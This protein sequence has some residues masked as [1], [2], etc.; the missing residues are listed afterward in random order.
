MML[1]HLVGTYIYFLQPRWQIQTR[2]SHLARVAENL[3]EKAELD[4]RGVT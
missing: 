1:A 3:A 2:V 4:L